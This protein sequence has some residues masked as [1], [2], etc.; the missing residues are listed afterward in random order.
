MELYDSINEWLFQNKISSLRHSL[1][2]S[3]RLSVLLLLISSAHLAVHMIAAYHMSKKSPEP[4]FPVPKEVWKIVPFWT[5]YVSSLD[6]I[7]TVF[8]NLK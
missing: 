1:L 2:K 7:L 4:K 3:H 5:S 8:D 6:Y